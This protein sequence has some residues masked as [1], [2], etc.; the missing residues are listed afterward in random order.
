MSRSQLYAFYHLKKDLLSDD[1]Y[2]RGIHL[3]DNDEFTSLKNNK[4]VYLESSVHPHQVSIDDFPGVEPDIQREKRSSSIVI[5][6]M[7]KETKEYYDFINRPNKL[8]ESNEI[9]RELLHINIPSEL[10]HQ[11]I[12]PYLIKNHIYTKVLKHSDYFGSYCL[13]NECILQCCFNKSQIKKVDANTN[14]LT[15]DLDIK[16]TLNT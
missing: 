10:I 5:K 6:H 1:I 14:T 11:I 12:W 13:S 16:F 8:S 7:E 15:F 9:F 4:A 2:L 3:L